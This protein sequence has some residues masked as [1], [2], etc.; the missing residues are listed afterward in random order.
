MQSL[1]ILSNSV[2]LQ[3]KFWA[4]VNTAE[5]PNGCWEWRRP[6][7]PGAYPYFQGLRANR[8]AWTIVKGKI[9]DGLFV[10]HHCDNRKCVR[11]EH[12]FTGTAKDNMQ[13]AARKGRVHLAMGES[14]GLSKLTP[15][16]VA[17]IKARYIK[18]NLAALAREFG[19][20]RQTL[21]PII[22][23]RTWRAVEPS[24]SPASVSFASSTPHSQHRLSF[25]RKRAGLDIT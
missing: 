3:R 5:H 19:V 12:L 6:V 13:D 18:G 7:K 20:R 25:L 17:T 8:L 9:P 23:G 10:C 14:N 2:D 1:E 22:K 15:E 21:D 24:A 4:Q 11:P 16:I